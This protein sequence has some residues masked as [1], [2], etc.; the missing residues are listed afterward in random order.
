MRKLDVTNSRVKAPPDWWKSGAFGVDENL[1]NKFFIDE[2]AHALSLVAATVSK[3]PRRKGSVFEAES[4][5]VI[6]SA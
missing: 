1:L 6:L 2:I 3:T 5:I 4:Q